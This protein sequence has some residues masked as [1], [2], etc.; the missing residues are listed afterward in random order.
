[1]AR[2]TWSSTRRSGRRQRRSSISHDSRRSRSSTSSFE[3]A[4]SG[5]GAR[6]R[7]GGLGDTA[8]RRRAVRRAV[9]VAL[10]ALH[11]DAEQALAELGG[12]VRLFPRELGAAEVAVRRRG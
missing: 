11:L 4:C 6:A 10:L 12:A 8:L 5:A 2:G 3:R 7:A 1:M 9:G